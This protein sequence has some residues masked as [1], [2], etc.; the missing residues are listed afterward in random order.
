[1]RKIYISLTGGLGNQLFQ[2]AA[3]MSIDENAEIIAIT[4]SGNPRRTGFYNSHLEK[5]NFPERIKFIHYRK[6]LFINKTI[7]YNLRSA[8]EPKKWETL[9]LYTK[10]IRMASTVILSMYLGKRVHMFV[11]KNVGFEKT[12][13]KTH[14]NIFMIGYFQS[15]N[16]INK[17]ILDQIRKMSIREEFNDDFFKLREAIIG[18]SGL[19]IHIRR[20]DYR[21]EPKIGL[22]SDKYFGTAIELHMKN[23]PYK[24][25]WIFSDEIESCLDLIPKRHR[26]KCTVVTKFMDDPCVTL[27]LLTFGKGYI[28]SNSS[29]SWWGAAL[30]TNREAVVIAPYPWFKEGESPNGIT[31]IDWVTIPAEWA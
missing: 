10:I 18:S 8:I 12:F 15:P 19:I 27:K 24:K 11:P 3:A 2:I 20:G 25:I 31:M 30:R 4:S 14:S 22:L 21:N 5:F 29:F 23:F 9:S 26:S 28:L 17:E 16:W 1:M 7:G 6:N 13:I